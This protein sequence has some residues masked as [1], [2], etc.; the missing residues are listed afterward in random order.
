[1]TAEIA[2]LNKS[3]V[4]LATDSA[5]T[6]S[7]GNA[8]QKVFDTADKLFELSNDQ[9]IGIMIYNGMQFSG[10]PLP[11]LIKEFRATK[12]NFETIESAAFTFLKFLNDQGKEAP[13][14]ETSLTIYN[15]IVP[16]LNII[17]ERI[18]DDF[19]KAIDKWQAADGEIETVYP[20][21][22]DKVIAIFERR[23]RARA[24]G[25]FLGSKTAPRLKKFEAEEIQRIVSEQFQSIKVDAIQKLVR[26]SKAVILSDFLSGSKTGIIIAGFGQNERFPSLV[27]VEIEGVLGGRLKFSETSRC[28]INR[29]GNRAFVRPFAQKEMVERFLYGLDDDIQSEII[30]FCK[31]TISAIPL[32][33]FDKLDFANP[34][35]REDLISRTKIAEDAFLRNL[36]EKAFKVIEERSRREIE[37]MIQFMPKPELAKMAEALIDLTSMKRKVSTGVETVGGPVDVAVISK[38]EGFVWVKRKHYFPP[39]LNNR[40]FQRNSKLNQQ[41]GQ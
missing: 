4:A 1:V 8:H 13:Q 9:P 17:Q 3:A 10:I 28:E 41:G 23:I 22:V 19:R 12:N 26:F 33:V 16:I 15:V 32:E 24:A 18:N 20:K 38:S 31:D 21:T 29:N 39:E 6:I 34:A 5:V 27:S 25:Q 7:A 30:R 11:D 37:D 14:S 35:D 2:I 36:K 40:Y